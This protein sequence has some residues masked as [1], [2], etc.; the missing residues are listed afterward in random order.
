M[1]GQL[2][3]VAFERYMLADDRPTHPMAFS[4]RLMFSGTPDVDALREAGRQAA[5]RHPLLSSNI[6][7]RTV[8]DFDWIPA[9][10]PAPW[11][12]IA[13]TGTPLRFPG[14]QQIDLQKQT[15][16]RI[17]VRYG[18]ERTEIRF[19][20]QH[21]ATDGLGAYRFIEDF[22]A[23]Y[24]AAYIGS[25][26]Q[27][28]WS[29]VDQ[30]RLLERDRFGLSR[31]QILLRLPVELWGIVIGMLMFFIPKPKPLAKPVAPVVTSDSALELIDPATFTLAGDDFAKLRAAAKKQGVTLNDLMLRDTFLAMDR[32]N[33]RHAPA[34]AGKLLRIMIPFSLR[35]PEDDATPAANIVGMVNLDRMLSI[36]RNPKW[37]LKTI[38]WEMNFLKHFRFAIAFVRCCEMLGKIPG[39]MRYLANPNRCFATAVFSNLG[40][41]FYNCPLVRPDGQLVAGNLS[42]EAVESAPPVRPFTAAGITS[43]SY[44]GGL[45]VVM[46]YDRYHFTPE[47]AKEF[48]AVMEDQFRQSAGIASSAHREAPSPSAAVA[49]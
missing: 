22:L 28:R 30:S 20:F 42:L 15:A 49:A 21:A 41:L 2:R 11:M 7:F 27:P 46:N 36:Y 12:D 38:R 10:D 9:G 5:E 45:T 19:Q 35:S 1:S 44:H 17:W 26:A 23:A 8:D 13:P 32:W 43:L 29:P 34:T 39:T 40:I 6:R 47:T 4:I 31:W 14:A 16:V 25:G 33:K 48:M 24:E 37:L 18:E 3:A